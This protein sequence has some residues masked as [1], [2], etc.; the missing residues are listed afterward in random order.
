M[1]KLNFNPAKY[2]SQPETFRVERIFNK[3]PQQIWPILA[4]HQGMVDWMPG[5]SAVDVTHNAEGNAGL[6]CKRSCQ[7]GSEKLEEEIVLWEPEL[8][9]GYKIFD[10]KLL[11]DHVAY[12]TIEDLGNGKSKVSWIQHLKPKG[13]IIKQLMMKHI[14]LPKTLKKALANLESRIAA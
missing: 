4:N 1:K 8:A 9:Y 7:F 3:T 6:A 13:N 11:S 14:M 10:N 5:I 2:S 12:V